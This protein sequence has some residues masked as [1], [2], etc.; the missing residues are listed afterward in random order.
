LIL[1]HAMRP[2]R[3]AW[4]AC[5][6]LLFPPV[7]APMA[8]IWKDCLM[9]GFLVLGVAGL[10]E[11]ARRWRIAGLAS[12]VAAT[13]MRYNA[14]AATLPLIVLLFEWRPAQRWFA[15]YPTAIGAWIAVTG[16][17][18]GCNAA[19]VDREMHFWHSSFAI[20]DIVGTL[21]H[22]EP[23]IPDSELGPLLAPTGVLVDH[24]YHA[25]LRAK[26]APA[27][28]Y[29]LISGDGR[30]WDLPLTGTT[31]AP[32]PTRD[33]ISHAWREILSAH[34]R[35]YLT[36]RVE[37]FAQALGLS[38]RQ[39]GA[40]VILHKVQYA[41]MMENMHLANSSSSFQEVGEA[42]AMWF[43]KKTRLFRPHVYALLA[44]VLLGFCRRQRDV[45]ALL[46]SGLGLELSLFPLVVT[47]DYRYSHW[48]TTCTCLALVML[49]ARRSGNR[50]GD[51]AGV[52]AQPRDIA[53]ADV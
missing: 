52:Q 4:L 26:Y 49:I 28:F 42:I 36:Y 3:A 53:A 5:A 34:L 1:R 40:T 16:L 48:L 37:A 11:P 17:A 47:P 12:L 39:E 22:V 29:Q 6:L 43:A 45:A 13:A 21:A 15:R 19:L 44:L 46:L 7:L 25:R 31:P 8:V 2:V 50:P 41:G 10:L 32:E 38:R 51:R 27:G 33:A 23:D 14:P 18:F 24:D 9:A 20:Q 30:L 35:A